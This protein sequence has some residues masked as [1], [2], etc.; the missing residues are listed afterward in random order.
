M[1]LQYLFPPEVEEDNPNIVLHYLYYG[2]LVSFVLCILVAG[3]FGFLAIQD[4]FLQ[5]NLI[6]GFVYNL[7]MAILF[8]IG[9]IHLHRG[10]FQQVLKFIVLL[11]LSGIALSAI[12]FGDGFYD[13]TFAFIFSLLAVSG[14]FISKRSLY[15]IG[16]VG[17]LIIVISYYV[18]WSNPALGHFPPPTIA[19]LTRYLSAI[20]I[21]TLF[22]Q[23]TIDQLRLKSDLLELRQQELEKKQ[24]ELT[25][26]QNKLIQLVEERT[27][28]LLKAKT[29]AEKASKSKSTFLANISHEL[30][31]P[32]NAIIGYSEMIEEDSILQNDRQQLA[33]DARKIKGA[34]NHLL[35]LINNILDLSKIEEQE[36]QIHAEVVHLNTIVDEVLFFI[37]P[38]L[39]NNNNRFH[40]EEQDENIMLWADPLR[41]KQILLNLLS[42]AAKFTENGEIH[43]RLSSDV[44]G[45]EEFAQIEIKD[46]GI[47]IDRSKLD[48]IFIPFHQIENVLTRKYTG[49]GLGLSLT[50]HLIELM[51]GSIIV[52]SN[53][54]Q[55]S[56]FTVLIPLYNR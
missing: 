6:A 35:K 37:M 13:V 5:K 38:L 53:P 45:K 8:A 18:A 42:N 14:P 30:R 48:D 29:E 27:A 36:L 9:L 22:L 31:T 43:L 28:E 55:G 4:R 50:K 34:G 15:L 52:E 7:L 19:K 47:G 51:H 3:Y 44:A 20:I 17:I 12:I 25:E 1:L 54:G 16:A 23:A 21:A 41:V 2:V 49:T 26:F 39:E 10:R 32:L 24:A 11:G 46:S 33:E 56:T 40:L